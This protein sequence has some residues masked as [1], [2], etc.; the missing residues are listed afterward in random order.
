MTKS[1]KNKN[2]IVIKGWVFAG[3]LAIWAIFIIVFMFRINIVEGVE[4]ERFAEKNNFRLDTVTAERGNSYASNG[5]LMAT[6][7]TKHN[8]Y[9]DLTVIKDELF[10]TEM[11]N[12]A[13]SLGKMFTKSPSYFYDKFST[14]RKKKNRYMMLVKDLDYEQYQRIKKFPIF[15][16]G[17]NK[18]GFIHETESKRELIVQ[19]IGVRTIGY[20]D[21]RGK[22]GLEG[23]YSDLLSGIEGRRWEQ[24]MGRGKWKPMKSWEQEPQAGSSVYTTIDADLQMVAYDALYKQLS[25]FEAQ[26]GS[27]VVM[28]V[29]TGKVRA[30]VNLSR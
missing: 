10:K 22:V 29:Q 8:V 19:D 17:Q 4:L 9:V 25:E 15:N 24:F 2:N 12:L 18:G 3:A 21:Q 16:K 5:A 20:D 23:A 6:T 14:E 30:I 7:V 28:E 1:A 13:D 11:H 26:H 27:V